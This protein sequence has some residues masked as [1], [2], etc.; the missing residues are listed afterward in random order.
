MISMEG[1]PHKLIRQV[2]QSALSSEFVLAKREDFRLSAEKLATSLTRGKDFDFLHQFSE[3]FAGR[4]VTALLHLPDNTA[5]QIAEDAS[6]L[7]LAMGPSA[8]RYQDKINAAYDRLSEMADGLL[9]K[10]MTGD[11]KASFAARILAAANKLDCKD[12]GALNDLIVIAIFGGVD[13]TRAQLAFAVELFA[14]YPDQ[15]RW[16]RRNRDA[17][18][19]AIE[20]VIRTRPTTTWSTREALETFEL[21]GFEIRKG[22]TVH[23]LVHATGTD[24][25][26]GGITGFDVT[27]RRKIH[28]GF[29]GGTHHCLGQLV[30]R[31]DMAEA[32]DVLL[33]HWTSIHLA[34]EPEY[35]PD[36][37][38][39]SPLTMPIRADWV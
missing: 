39:T 37:G 10:A 21:D 14:R 11:D 15:W 34:A 38:N 13:T 23:V 32:L 18:P 12:M 5:N 8:L 2:A 30:A 36:S 9:S 4:A 26:V 16:L 31:T 20:E 7:G 17:I 6:S 3:P 27:A 24:P 29:G 33:G 1:A 19:Q 28:F 25:E 35:L 22:E